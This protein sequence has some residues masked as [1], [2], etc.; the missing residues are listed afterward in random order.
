MF[1]HKYD[2]SIHADTQKFFWLLRLHRLRLNDEL[3]V[4]YLFAVMSDILI[5]Y[6]SSW[7][8]WPL[9]DKFG[10]R[11]LWRLIKLLNMKEMIYCNHSELL[12]LKCLFTH[13]P[14]NKPFWK[15]HF[16]NFGWYLLFINTW[17]WVVCVISQCLR[18]CQFKLIAWAVW[19]VEVNSY[20]SCTWQRIAGLRKNGTE[21]SFSL[22]P[23]LVL[24]AD[25]WCQVEHV[26]LCMKW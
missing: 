7:P 1:Y 18:F 23:F 25:Y 14:P 20:C 17:S 24:K 3:H 10:C 6:T 9:F 12:I 4:D 16:W 2:C 21:V 26:Q 19:P 13:C 15:F 8:S 5:E 11:G 22:E